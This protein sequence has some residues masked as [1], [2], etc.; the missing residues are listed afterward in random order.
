VD[1]LGGARKRAK[2]F[3]IPL[4]IGLSDIV[5]PERCPVLGIALV[6]GD[7]PTPASPSLDRIDPRRGYVPGNVQVISTRAN[8]MKSDASLAEL[9]LFARW[10]D[11]LAE[12]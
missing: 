7:R 1:L 5:I 3:G 4:E 10:V 11:T 6:R 9:R 8:R 12:G 2:L